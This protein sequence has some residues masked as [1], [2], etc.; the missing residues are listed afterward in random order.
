MD[1]VDPPEGDVILVHLGSSGSRLLYGP[2]IADAA[3][4]GARLVGYDR[5]GQGGSTR[6]P[7]RAVADL[8]ADLRAIAVAHGVERLVTS[9]LSGGGPHA[10]ACA[11]LAPDL[12]AAIATFASVGPFGAEGLDFLAGMGG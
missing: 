11:A 3:A 10:L 1:I 4:R 8:V 9:G 12:V 6:L 5:P 7:A 2:A